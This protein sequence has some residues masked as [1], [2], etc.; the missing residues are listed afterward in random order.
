MMVSFVALSYN[1]LKI[2]L[3]TEDEIVIE[4]ETP[5]EEEPE[6]VDPN[7]IATVDYVKGVKIAEMSN[8]CNKVITNGFDVFLSDDNLHHFWDSIIEAKK[9]YH[10]SNI[11]AVLCGKRHTACGYVWRYEN[12]HFHKYDI[13]K[14]KPIK[15]RK[16][17]N[18]PV[19][20]YDKAG[21]F[22]CRYNDVY[23]ISK[24]EFVCG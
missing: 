1:T 10:S 7:D 22:I 9:V 23:E 14:K 16:Y 17:D 18:M 11:D 20:Q 2:A 6:Y 12:E 3:E 5:I 19:Y 8:T 13:E 4:P 15:Q 24:E 21:N